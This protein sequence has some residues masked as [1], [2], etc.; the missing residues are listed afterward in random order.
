MNT[1]SFNKVFAL[2]YLV[3]YALALLLAYAL[4]YPDN[5]AGTLFFKKFCFYL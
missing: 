4:L 3:A 2:G 1:T 5:Y